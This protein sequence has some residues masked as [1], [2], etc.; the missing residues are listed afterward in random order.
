MAVRSSGPCNRRAL[1]VLECAQA[2]R[3]RRCARRTPSR[4]AFLEAA[5]VGLA[6]ALCSASPDASPCC[7]ALSVCCRMR[8]EPCELEQRDLSSARGTAR[9]PCR[10]EIGELAR[11]PSPRCKPGCAS[12][13]TRAARSSRRRPTSC[14]RR[15]HRWTAMLELLG[16]RSR[17]ASLDLA[18][19]RQRVARRARA[20][21]PARAGWPP[22]CSTSAGST[23]RSSCALSPSSSASG[24]RGAGRVRAAGTRAR[25]VTITSTTDRRRPSWAQADPAASP[26]S[27]AS[28][29]TMRCE[30][31]TGRA[32]GQVALRIR[33]GAD[34]RGLRHGPGVPVDE[35]ELIFERFSAAATPGTTPGSGSGWRSAASSPPAWAA[36]SC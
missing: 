20:V 15:S 1:Y 25:G 34:D 30:S 3:V 11:G 18:D 10:D 2:A 27:C 23:P 17:R 35:R 26:G 8:A 7:A 29:S 32:R 5:A 21:A 28:C 31:R 22:T 36:P 4:R 12:R 33:H 6:D 19:A 13:R 16:G 9:T 14:A 24:A